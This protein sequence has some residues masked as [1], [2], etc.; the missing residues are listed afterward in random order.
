MT[1]IVDKPHGPVGEREMQKMYGP[2]HAAVTLTKD[3]TIRLQQAEIERL[4]VALE[5]AE[6]TASLTAAAS[7]ERLR[8]LLREYADVVRL[9]R[10]GKPVPLAYLEDRIREALGDKNS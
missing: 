8:G 4:R 5:R 1:K 9:V 2:A 7:I 6:R 10:E 3:D